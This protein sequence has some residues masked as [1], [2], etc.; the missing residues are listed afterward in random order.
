V[1]GDAATAKQFGKCDEIKARDAVLEILKAIAALGREGRARDL[2]RQALKRILVESQRS[3]LPPGAI[4]PLAGEMSGRT[5]GGNVGRCHSQKQRRNKILPLT[6]GR[7]AFPIALPFGHAPVDDLIGFVRKVETCGIAEISLAPRRTL[8]LLCPS[9]TSAKVAQTIAGNADFI[10][11]ADDPRAN[12]AACPGAPACASGHIPAR[13]M[14]AE[15]AATMPGGLDLHVSGCEKRCAKPGHKGL[16]LLGFSD[17]ARLVLEGAGPAPLA[18]V[19]RGEAVAAVGRV[20]G[21]VASSR[22][23]GESEAQCLERIDKNRLAKVFA[24]EH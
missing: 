12:I 19:A 22:K 20:A 13:T 17:G 14:A 15:I 1:A 5:E 3:T 8:I 7:F 10:V 16:T 18:H 4:S 24:G 23:P 2:S 11:D 21:L 6:D 9:E